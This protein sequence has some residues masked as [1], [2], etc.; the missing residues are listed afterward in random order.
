MHNKGLPQRNAGSFN[1]Y[2]S[3]SELK[4]EQNAAHVLQPIRQIVNYSFQFSKALESL[5]CKFNCRWLRTNRIPINFHTVKTLTY[6]HASILH[7]SPWSVIDWWRTLFTGPS[8]PQFSIF[9][10]YAIKYIKM[11]FICTSGY[12]QYLQPCDSR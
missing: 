4:T 9:L 5:D 7:A 3:Q 8:T 1:V 6:F 12:N 10:T 11:F 2:I